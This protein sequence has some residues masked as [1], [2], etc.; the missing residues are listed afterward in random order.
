MKAVGGS[1]W[2]RAVAPADVS[3]IVCAHSDERRRALRDAVASVRHQ[4]EPPLETLVVIDH[5]PSLADWARRELDAT[6]LENDRSRGASGARNAGAA[7]ARG[8]TLVFLDDDAVAGAAWLTP[9][10]APFAN[11]QVVGVGGRI[12]PAWA[13]QRP[14]WFPD[15]FLWTVGASYTGQHANG[16][17][18]GAVRNV[19]TGNMAIRRPAFDLVGGFLESFGKQ[20]AASAPEDTELSLRVTR[21]FPHALWYFAPGAVVR[22]HVPEER[23]TAA[24]FL[25]RCYSEGR[26]KAA[27]ASV[28]GG[29]VLGAE[30]SF[31]AG[32]LPRAFAAEIRRCLS[33][34]VAGLARAGAIAAGTAATGAGYAAGLLRSR[35]AAPT[36]RA[37]RRAA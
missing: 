5:N 2:S 23:A 21:R 26:G 12:E 32:P 24:F 33:G 20:G 31:L 35:R 18:G 28:L 8:S 29:N 16:V 6:V 19:W 13:A 22:H 34:D 17:A 1:E 3:A 37:G 30:A 15:A 36:V 27:L 11:P 10:V 7:R 4:P 25:R 9:L 14:L